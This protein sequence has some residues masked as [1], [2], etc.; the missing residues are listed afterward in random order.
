MKLQGRYVDV[1]Y[2][3]REVKNVKSVLR[4]RRSDVA[5]FHSQIYS[6]ALRMARSVDAK[7]SKTSSS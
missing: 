2:A 6:K 7:E 5:T 1:A 3:Y 4:S